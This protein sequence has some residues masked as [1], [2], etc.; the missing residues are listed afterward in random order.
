M[1]SDD[2][3]VPNRVEQQLEY[4]QTH[5]ETDVIGGQIEEFIDN[6]H[7]IVGKRVVPLSNTDIILYMKQYLIWRNG[8]LRHTLKCKPKKVGLIVLIHSHTNGVGWV[9][10]FHR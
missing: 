8:L 4:L 2:I 7:H 9:L 1:D 6:T 5:T 10:L 3:A